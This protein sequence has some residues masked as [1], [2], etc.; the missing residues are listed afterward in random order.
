MEVIQVDLA[1][2][3]KLVDEIEKTEGEGSAGVR[4]RGWKPSN[5]KQLN[6]AVASV[7]ATKT[8]GNSYIVYTRHIE[9]READWF[10]GERTGVVNTVTKLVG[11]T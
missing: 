3:L 2:C 9:K 4:P 8:I 7:V 5:V 11:C 1:L 10:G 6:M